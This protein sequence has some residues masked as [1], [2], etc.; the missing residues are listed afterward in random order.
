MRGFAALVLVA[1]G[2]AG[3]QSEAQQREAI[4]K[5]ETDGCIRGFEQRAADQPGAVP[6]GVSAPRIC[7][8]AVS[9]ATADMSMEELRALSGREPTPGE[10]QVIGACVVEEAQRAGVIAN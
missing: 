4:V 2:T 5:A 9:R 6:P 10:V 8:C 1:L 3:C 7:E